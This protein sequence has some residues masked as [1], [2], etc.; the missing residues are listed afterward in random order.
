MDL[1]PTTALRLVF[2]V[3]PVTIKTAVLNLL[4]LSENAAKQSLRTEVLIAIIRTLVNIPNSIGRIQG[5]GNKDPGIKGGIWI[6]K[7]TIPA[8]SETVTVDAVLR[9][10]RD[11]D[12]RAEEVEYVPPTLSAADFEAEWTGPRRDVAKDA[13]RPDISEREQYEKLVEESPSDTTIL[14]FHGGGYFCM[15]V[16][17]ALTLLPNLL[18]WSP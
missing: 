1:S 17:H 5:L 2:Q 13:P 11:L 18:T 8:S 16:S 4:R 3:A 12:E 14:Y 10:V 15:D 9:A 6:S 7:V